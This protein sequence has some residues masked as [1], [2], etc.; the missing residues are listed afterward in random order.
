MSSSVFVK[1]RGADHRANS[2]ASYAADRLRQ[3]LQRCK[4]RI[5]VC[6]LFNSVKLSHHGAVL[7]LVAK[8]TGSKPQ[9]T[10]FVRFLAV[11]GLLFDIA[12]GLGNANQVMAAEPTPRR[13][14]SVNLEGQ[15]T[16]DFRV[17]I[18]DKPLREALQAIA[19]AGKV[20]L[21]LDR[22]VDPTT[23]ISTDPSANTIYRAL[24]SAAKSADVE[25]YVI[26]NVAL[27]GRTAWV[28]RTAAAI[29]ALPY[30]GK[31]ATIAWPE[32][33]TPSE[34]WLAC[35][36]DSDP[37]SNVEA[38][39]PHDLW[40]ATR[41]V[42]MPIDSARLLVMA[43]F[44]LQMASPEQASP[45]ALELSSSTVLYPPGKHA[46]AMRAA[47]LAQDPSALIKES[48]GQLLVTT[49]PKAHRLAT[50]VWL[51][52]PSA[53]A[54]KVIDVD[55]VRFTLRLQNAVAEQ[56]LNQLAGT[57]GRKLSIDAAV[58]E[59]CKQTV[60]LTVKDETLRGLSE[61]IA[62]QVKVQVSWTDTQL[63]VSAL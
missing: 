43:Q 14:V 16:S 55:K 57:S 27:V 26:E 50:D 42:D 47:I 52:T 41:W 8:K 28:D 12:C 51:S 32:L 15:L 62:E 35:T 45:S 11:T 29:R 24:A 31:P 30:Q 46:A 13:A 58:A 53:N 4:I 40:P 54:T 10:A 34:A 36:T 2:G 63:N 59:A 23:P 17:S 33:T 6:R 18:T 39:L 7:S 38:A 19:E 37:P 5:R 21:W 44:D 20:N 22:Q 49:S 48:G 1:N 56:V 60:S 61:R 25:L 9:T 3:A